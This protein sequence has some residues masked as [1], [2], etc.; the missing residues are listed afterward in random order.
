[1]IKCS[2]FAAK[3]TEL[4]DRAAQIKLQVDALERNHDENSDIA[5]KA[6]ELSQSLMDKWV[7]ADCSTKRRILEIVCLNLRLDDVTLVPT[8]RK[9]FDMLAKGLLSK[10]SRG[11]RI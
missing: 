9:P 4:R 7:T 1:M 6:F 8:I 11:E 2:T 5:L 10:D 3:D